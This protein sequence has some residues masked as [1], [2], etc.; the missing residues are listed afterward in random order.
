MIPPG[1]KGL[2]LGHFG[3]LSLDTTLLTGLNAEGAVSR[4]DSQSLFQKKKFSAA[5]CG[6]LRPQ[7]LILPQSAI[8]NPPSAIRPVLARCLGSHVLGQNPRVLS[9]VFLIDDW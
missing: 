6:T 2:G 7:R 5:L 4:G 1:R 3:F 9:V 8:P